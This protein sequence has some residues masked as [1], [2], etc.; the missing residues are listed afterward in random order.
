[1]GG[2]RTGWLG[3]L[4]FGAR[5]ETMMLFP[6]SC[7]LRYLHY[8]GVGKYILLL[9]EK[10]GAGL[11]WADPT[12]FTKELFMQFQSQAALRHFGANAVLRMTQ[13]DNK[14]IL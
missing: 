4:R 1:M 7:L 11:G 5:G 3:G 12:V 14:T 9:T 2:C 8:S 6:H 13:A 10:G